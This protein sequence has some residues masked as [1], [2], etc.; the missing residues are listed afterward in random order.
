M[1]V[2][3]LIF[4]LDGTLID[5]AVLCASILTEM[6]R[7]R[8]SSR[9]V[10][11]DCAKP[12]MSGGGE[13]LVSTMLGPDCGDVAAELIEFRCRYAELPTPETSLFD[14]VLPGL[15]RLHARGFGLAICSNK[16]QH[17]CEKVVSDLGI[18]PLF[19]AVIG[20]ADG[21]QPKPHPELLDLA[22]EALE[23][24]P[25]DCLF[26]GDSDVDHAVAKASGVPFLLVDYGYA[27]PQ[28]DRSG[29]VEFSHFAD[30][31]EAVTV[32]HGSSPLERRAA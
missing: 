6:L 14:G 27:P 8:G 23:S 7:D 21:R 32:A 28:W 19:S 13:H 3:S 12:H 5:S 30:L 17:L 16:P 4:D 15:K 11:R 25:A 10:T 2:R 31:V 26:V 29:M 1:T 24:R 18:E 20:S 9:I 22:M